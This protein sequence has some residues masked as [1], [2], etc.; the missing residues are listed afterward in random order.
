MG[1]SGPKGSYRLPATEYRL[2]VSLLNQPNWH[3]S[4]H[5]I[6][7]D[8][9]DAECIDDLGA[10]RKCVERLNRALKVVSERAAVSW[11]IGWL[12]LAIKDL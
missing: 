6:S 11:A 7:R 12:T 2:L 8:A 9:R 5:Q 1:V 4:A 10:M 3:A